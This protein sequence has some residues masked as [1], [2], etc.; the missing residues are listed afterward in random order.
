MFWASPPYIGCPSDGF[1]GWSTIFRGL[2]WFRVSSV[3]GGS[4]GLR[5][6]LSIEC[7]LESS[8]LRVSFWAGFVVAVEERGECFCGFVLF[9][10][11][12]YF[13]LFFLFLYIVKVVRVWLYGVWFGFIW[14]WW[15]LAFCPSVSGFSFCSLY[16]F[17]GRSHLV[18]SIFW[19][20]RRANL[21]F[22]VLSP[23]W[24]VLS[25]GGVVVVDPEAVWLGSA[26][27]RVESILWT[28]R[29]KFIFYSGS[30]FDIRTLGF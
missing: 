29:H 17:D 7:G 3:L 6:S 19:T 5:N 30:P 9:F 28:P 2:A 8:A 27:F 13:F 16:P 18:K 25:W 11:S 24:W 20:P 26:L 22:T 21:F 15:L 4:L 23:F 1:S 10:L 12:F 14:S